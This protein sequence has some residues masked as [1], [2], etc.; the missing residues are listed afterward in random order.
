[1]NFLA[2]PAP[3]SASPLGEEVRRKLR[4]VRTCQARSRWRWKIRNRQP[5]SAGNSRWLVEFFP[6]CDR[7]KM[8]RTRGRAVKSFFCELLLIRFL[9]L[10]VVRRGNILRCTD[11][12]AGIHRKQAEICEGVAVMIAPAV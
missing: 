7:T 4:Y 2:I 6:V 8:P 5:G 3:L 9:R 10:L 11:G 12:V 1:M